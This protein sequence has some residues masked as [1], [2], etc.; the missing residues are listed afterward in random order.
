MPDAGVLAAGS[1]TAVFIAEGWRL[2]S[3]YWYGNIGM[4]TSAIKLRLSTLVVAFATT[5]AAA[6]GA[7]AQ[8]PSQQQINTIKQSC[9]SDYMNVCASVPTGGRAALQCLQQHQSDVSAPCQS[10][11]AAIG[12]VATSP[13]GSTQRSEAVPQSVPPHSVPPQSA[14]PLS[15]RQQAALMR[16]ACGEDFRAYCRG[17]GLGGGHAIACLSEN[18][19][20]LS[21]GCRSALAEARE[22]R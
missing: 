20:R 5:L 13:T 3:S 7:S 11:L 15:I 12:G 8:Q 2:L 4:I 9:R 17:V 1:V 18:Q 6:S 10:A 21:P 19:A 22:H 16:R 14:A